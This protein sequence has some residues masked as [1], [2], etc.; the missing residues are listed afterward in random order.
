MKIKM[1]NEIN[2]FGAA[3]KFILDCMVQV[4]EGTLPPSAINALINGMK[5]VNENIQAE[6]NVA[7]VSLL[8]EKEGKKF[9]ENVVM[10]K[11]KINE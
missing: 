3:R 7:K 2:D 5:V 9:A 8:Y 1:L 4:R 6:V 11:T 10:G